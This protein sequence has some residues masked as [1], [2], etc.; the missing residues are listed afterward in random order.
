MGSGKISPLRVKDFYEKTRPILELMTLSGQTGL[1][2][3][4][5]ARSLRGGLRRIKVWGRKEIHALEALPARTRGAA[6]DQK[7]KD[8]TVCIILS[9][10]LTFPA[11]VKKEAKKRSVALFGSRHTRIKCQEAVKHFFAS[12]PAVTTIPGGLLQ[13]FGIG[14]LIRGDSGI[15]KSECALELIS[16]GHRFISD[17]VTQITRTKEGALIG[18]TPSVSRCLMEIRGLG[19]INIRKI[20]GARAVASRAEIGLIIQLEK[21]GEGKKYDRLGLKSWKDVQILDR[22]IARIII[23]V[24]PGRNM[25][26]LVEVACKVHMLREKGYIAPQDLTKRLNRALSVRS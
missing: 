8:G 16:R 1:S 4:L 10:G 14:V 25:A 23:P 22:K 19:I 15:G 26:T 6:F 12:V 18:K 13:V 17:D 3:S 21:W 24:A 7:T 11:E 20:F 9:E 2:R 5:P